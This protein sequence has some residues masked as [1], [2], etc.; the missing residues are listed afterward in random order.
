MRYQGAV[1]ATIVCATPFA[2]TAQP[3]QGLYIGAGVGLHM[4]QSP[5]I[6]P[7]SPG[8]GTGRAN[9]QENLGFAAMGSLGY[10][11]FRPYLEGHSSLPECVQRLKYDAHAFARRQDSWFRRLPAQPDDG[12]GN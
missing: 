12:A 10:I 4:P 5:N 11:Q 3:I 9:L 8:F 1:L 6:T 2:A 7:L